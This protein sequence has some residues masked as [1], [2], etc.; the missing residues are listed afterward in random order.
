MAEANIRKMCF[1][2]NCRRAQYRLIWNTLKSESTLEVKD[3]TLQKW[4]YT[5]P[6]RQVKLMHV[7]SFLTN[8]AIWKELAKHG[9]IQ[10]Q[11]KTELLYLPSGRATTIKK[12]HVSEDCPDREKPEFNSS[13]TKVTRAGAPDS[14]KPS[15]ALVAS[16]NNKGNNLY[17]TFP[18]DVLVQGKLSDAIY[19]IPEKQMEVS[20]ED[21]LSKFAVTD[22]LKQVELFFRNKLQ[23]S[24]AIS[25]GLDDC[26]K[27]L[28]KLSQEK[29]DKLANGN[30]KLV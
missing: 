28:S 26:F 6:I 8:E 10:T 22:R 5:N 16:G 21:A 17:E 15:H 25:L 7:Q 30:W 14:E 18:S 13:I 1:S 3:R 4:Q 20:F 27:D 2:E 23:P 19:K 29:Q 24:E 9:T 12:A 11:M